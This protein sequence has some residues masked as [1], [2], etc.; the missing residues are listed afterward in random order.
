[1]DEKVIE[2]FTDV[3]VK[4][5]DLY[6]ANEEESKLTRKES[7]HLENL[8][9]ASQPPI[10]ALKRQSHYMVLENKKIPAKMLKKNIKIEKKKN[11]NFPKLASMDS[12]LSVTARTTLGMLTTYHFVHN[13]STPLTYQHIS[14]LTDTYIGQG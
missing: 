2:S 14:P 13:Q 4:S 6:S 3:E 12:S 5:L 10:P 8:D 7:S 11:G 9:L 1:M